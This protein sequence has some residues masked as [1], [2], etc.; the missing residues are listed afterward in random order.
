MRLGWRTTRVNW[1]EVIGDM[2]GGDT[3]ILGL[4]LG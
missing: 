2:D 4:E 1:M 3:R